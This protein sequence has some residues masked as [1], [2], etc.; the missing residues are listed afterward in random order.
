MAAAVVLRSEERQRA[1][2]RE[3]RTEAQIDPDRYERV[4]GH[5]GLGRIEDSGGGSGS[6]ECA[7]RIEREEAM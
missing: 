5:T 4:R 2:A 6:G 7:G 3:G 1:R